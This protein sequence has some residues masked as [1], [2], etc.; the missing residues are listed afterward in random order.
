MFVIYVMNLVVKWFK[1][2]MGGF[3]VVVEVN[4]CKVFKFY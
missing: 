4:Y 2:E 3:D 1:D